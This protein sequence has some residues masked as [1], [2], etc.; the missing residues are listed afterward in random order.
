M[1]IVHCLVLA[2]LALPMTASA[3][4]QTRRTPSF[5]ECDHEN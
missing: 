4:T 1:K 5:M 3:Q 2:A